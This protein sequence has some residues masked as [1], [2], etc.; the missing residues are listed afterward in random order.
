MQYVTKNQYQA[1]YQHRRRAGRNGIKFQFTYYQWMDWWITQLGADFPKLR[2][3][4]RG[5]YCMARKGDKGPYHPDNVECLTFEQNIR[6][7]WGNGIHASHRGMKLTAAEAQMIKN[8]KGRYRVIAAK[9]GISQSMVS[10]IKRGINW[11]V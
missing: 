1:Y 3:R 5:K 6:D 2:G 11:S 8:M 7:A 9:F 10:H 4:G